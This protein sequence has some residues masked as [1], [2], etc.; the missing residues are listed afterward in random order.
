MRFDRSLTD[1]SLMRC[2]QYTYI[3]DVSNKKVELMLKI[4]TTAVCNCCKVNL[5][6][7]VVFSVVSSESGQNAPT[8]V[9]R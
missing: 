6:I 5:P 3:H 8:I 1:S 7:S 9:I 2:T 4:R